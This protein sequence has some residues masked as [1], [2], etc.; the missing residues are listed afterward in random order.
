MY[1]KDLKEGTAYELVQAL[2]D[3]ALAVGKVGLS[4]MVEDEEG[5]VEHISALWYDR[6]RDMIRM[7]V[8]DVKFEDYGEDL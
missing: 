6:E 7:S 3:I 8:N 5:R 1:E 4:V 2:Q